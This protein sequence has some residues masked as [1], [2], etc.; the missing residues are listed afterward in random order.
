MKFTLKEL[1]GAR[2]FLD[3]CEPEPGEGELRYPWLVLSL[4]VDERLKAIRADME[5]LEEDRRIREAALF[6]KD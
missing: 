4:M 1:E 5:R 2:E 6:R 3:K